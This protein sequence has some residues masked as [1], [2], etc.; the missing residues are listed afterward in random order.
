M[1]TLFSFNRFH[2]ISVKWRPTTKGKGNSKFTFDL[3]ST[4]LQIKT[5]S[6]VGSI[7][8][9]RVHMYATDDSFKGGVKVSFKS[10]M[11]YLFSSCT[12]WTK[13]PVQPPEAVDKTWT[14][15]KTDTTL[16]IECNGVEVLN[17]QFS[18][19]S[20]S[21]CLPKWGGDVVEKILIPN[22]DTASDFYR[23]YGEFHKSSKLPQIINVNSIHQ[24]AP[25]SPWMDQYKEVGTI[26]ILVRR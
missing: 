13:F 10:P 4:P 25:D 21:D 15:R 24:C 11:K 7:D 3:E 20:D 9:M 22:D 14:F 12:G 18:D 6:T 19:S 5:N 2:L 26:R 1:A 8:V 17:Y 23:S 16:S